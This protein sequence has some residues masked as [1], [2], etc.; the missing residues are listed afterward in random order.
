MVRIDRS[1]EVFR[2]RVG[3]AVCGGGGGERPTNRGSE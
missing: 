1:G 2:H 3:M